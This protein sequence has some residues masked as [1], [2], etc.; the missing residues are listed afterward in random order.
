MLIYDTVTLDP[1]TFDSFRAAYPP[2]A[3]GL[4]SIL[5]IRTVSYEYREQLVPS[6]TTNFTWSLPLHISSIRR[7][8]FCWNRNQVD[9]TGCADGNL[10][11]V[12]PNLRNIMVR[13][14]GVPFPQSG[15]DCTKP[16][17]VLASNLTSFG[18]L[19]TPFAYTPM[20]SNLSFLRSD[21]ASGTGRTDYLEYIQLD[22]EAQ[23]S[24]GSNC[25]YIIID[26]EALQNR[27]DLV[28]GIAAQ[29]ASVFVEMQMLAATTVD[30]NMRCWVE[31]DRIIQYDLNSPMVAV[32]Y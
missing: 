31:H 3:A 16:T 19:H 1:A 6:G 12:N 21:T 27:D 4:P 18:A 24:M 23:G 29:G 28:S 20:F 32:K 13:A 30:W 11:S 25:F 15:L 26:T 22:P 7:F 2:Q 14:N 8:F 10:G 5:P 9:A 17:T